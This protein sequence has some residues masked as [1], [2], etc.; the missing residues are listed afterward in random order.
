MQ[1][2]RNTFFYI[3]TISGFSLLI[4]WILLRGGKLEDGREII[5]S[6]SEKTQ[7]QEFV[8][9]FLYN[10][11]HPLAILL[12]QIVTIIIVARI[13]GWICTRIGQ[14][15][16][17]GEMIAGIVLGPSLMG[18]YFPESSAVL[19]PAQSLGNRQFL[20]QVGLILFMYIVGME[21]DLNVLR[22]KAHE[23]VVV[24]HASIVIPFALGTGLAYFIYDQ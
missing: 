16:V 10:L 17:I 4:Y 12:A 18:M 21:L 2:L 23:A 11:H 7:W 20:S 8:D 15:T 19:F 13:F 14:P 9:A 22:N 5:V 1:K 24:S 3:G 6:T